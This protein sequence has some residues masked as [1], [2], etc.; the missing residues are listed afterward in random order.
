MDMLTD[1]A[2]MS[3]ECSDILDINCRLHSDGFVITREHVRALCQN[4]RN[5]SKHYF[6]E[7]DGEVFAPMDSLVV[8]VTP[9]LVRLLSSTA[10]SNDFLK[11]LHL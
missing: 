6:Q 8:S 10:V 1:Y 3:T 2:D 4:S 9:N 11:I 5:H 7:V